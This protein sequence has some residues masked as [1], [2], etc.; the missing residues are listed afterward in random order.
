MMKH[1]LYIFKHCALKANGT[2]I[3]RIEQRLLVQL[4]AKD[5]ANR[6]MYSVETEIFSSTIV[7]CPS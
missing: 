4:L 2:I 1:F 7:L 5:R 6:A 3:S